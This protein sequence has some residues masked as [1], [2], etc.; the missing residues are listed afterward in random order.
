MAD[1]EMFEVRGADLWP[2]ADFDMSTNGLTL[3]GYAAVFN[4]PS[5]PLPG[6]KG[7]F[8]ETIRSTAFRDSL[9][10]N[11]DVTLR[12]QHNLTTLPLARTKS[13]TLKLSTTDH[14]LLAEAQLP[15]NEI[16]RPVRDAIQRGD[17]GGMSFRFRVPSK[18]GEKWSKDFRQRDLI[19]VELGN[20]VSVVD[21]PAYPD[22]SVAVRQLAAIA[23]VEPDELAE[24]FAVLRAD[25]T[26]LTS[27]QQRLLEAA[28]NAKA[29]APGIPP[30]VARARERLAALA[31]SK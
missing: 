10:R 24:A 28:I 31:S 4:L 2:N 27:E 22:T 14:G 17:I 18:A 25:D 5:A 23:D 7:M 15:D 6:P 8:T 26:K 30:S 21:F 29:E 3:R 9:N 20:E 16:G 11:P 13:G 19:A 1:Y 12:Y